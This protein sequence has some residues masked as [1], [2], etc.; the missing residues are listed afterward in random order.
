MQPTIGNAV[1]QEEFSSQEQVL[2]RPASLFLLAGL[3]EPSEP[4]F[5]ISDQDVQE[6][7]ASQARGSSSSEPH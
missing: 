5:C 1:T 7:R 6:W 2:P 4:L 3:P